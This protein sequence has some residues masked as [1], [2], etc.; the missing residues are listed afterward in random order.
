MSEYKYRVNLFYSYCHKDEHYRERME[1]ALA[2]LRAEGSLT[3]WSDRKI[4]PGTPFSPQII[5]KLI[6]AELAFFLVSPDFLASQ[7][8]TD[9]WKMARQNAKKTGQKLVPIILKPCA[10]KDFDSMSVYLALPED[11]CPISKWDDEDA[12]WQD[13]Y[14]QIKRVLEEIRCTFDVKEAYREEIYASRLYFPESA[15][16]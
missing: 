4:I 6:G 3:E 9:E 15:R 12:A 16:H 10:W 2:Q 5:E 1:V 13:I 14:E 8:C 11:G 7:A